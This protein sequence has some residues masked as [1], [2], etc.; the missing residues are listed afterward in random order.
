MKKL[1]YS[2]IAIVAAG[3]LSS[4]CNSLNLAPEDYYGSD[5]FWN[6]ASQVETFSLGLHKQIRD[7]YNMFFVLGECRGG[8]FRFGTSSQNVSP[9]Y[10]APIKTNTFTA[11]STGVSDWFGLYSNILQV[12]H[13]IEKVSKECK[14][15]SDAER[16]YYL[17]EAYGIRA[18]Y[19]F[20]LYRTYGGV[21]L[22][23]EVRVMN[24]AANASDLYLERSSAENTLKQIKTDIT[25]SETAFGSS[26][27]IKSKYIWSPYATQMLKA[28]V[29]LWSAKVATDDHKPGGKADFDVAEKALNT[30]ISSKKFKLMDD[31]KTVFTNKVNDEV[32]FS[33]YFNKT[34]ATN[35]GSQFLCNPGD[36]LAFCSAEENGPFFTVDPLNIVTTGIHR[37]E[38]S[39]GFVRSFD[40]QDKR[41]AATFFEYYAN[42]TLPGALMLKYMGNYYAS[43]NVRAYDSDVIVFRYADALLMMAEVQNGLGQDPSNYINQIRK[44]A[45]GNESHKYTNGTFAENELAILKE[46][47]FEFVGEGTRWWDL[48]RMQDANKKSLVFSSAAAYKHELNETPKAILSESDAYM[49]LWPIDVTVLNDDKLIKQNPQY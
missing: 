26:T 19:Y 3:L 5:S 34:E 28:Q 21:P 7:K 9:N 16:N 11:S 36:L 49:I 31:F 20:V 43:E 1:L 33:I 13:F 17:G 39:P 12:N 46:R 30:I 32:I 14:F 8:T 6:N 29:Y 37:H 10:E 27:Q 35:I 2:T 15:L 22:E 48:V 40:S 42:G 38:Y 23:L 4:G 25:N 24:G 47:D 44:R 41:R 45:F 18:L